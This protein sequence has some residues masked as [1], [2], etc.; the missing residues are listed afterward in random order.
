MLDDSA[1]QQKS[2]KKS[3]IIP[4]RRGTLLWYEITLLR[5]RKD[6]FGSGVEPETGNHTNRRKD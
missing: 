5:T 4:P 3:A 6:N 1:R 2:R